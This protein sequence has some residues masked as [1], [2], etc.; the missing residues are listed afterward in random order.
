MQRYKILIVDD[1]EAVLTI[2]ADAL[3]HDDY[4]I[5]TAQSG[6]EGL[7]KLETHEVHLII[8]DQKMPGMNGLEFL[9]KVQNKYPDVLTIMLTGYA[10]IKTAVQAINETGV[11]KFILKPWKVEDLRLTVRRALELRTMIMERDSLLVQVKRQDAAF[12]A[13]E[14]EYPGITKIDRDQNGNVIVGL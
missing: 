6:R 14:K 8:C 12:R 7:L 11:Y 10:D 1:E 5:L 13:I 2:T 4:H 3:S 9:E